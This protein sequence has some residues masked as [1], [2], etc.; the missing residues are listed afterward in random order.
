MDLVWG[1]GGARA[2]HP[3]SPAAGDTPLSVPTYLEPGSHQEIHQ[4]RLELGLP[5][6]E[7]VAADEDAALG[8]QFHRPRHEGVLGG[9]VDV[10]AALQDAGHGE[11]RGRGHL[12]A[13]L[14][15]HGAAQRHR[16]AGATLP[17]PSPAP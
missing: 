2:G 8:G 1:R 6:L 7:V 11:E 14:R 15:G 5:R 3:L 13:S 4:H 17:L 10:G 16:R 12:Q 9:P